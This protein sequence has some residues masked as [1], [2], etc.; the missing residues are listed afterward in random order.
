MAIKRLDH[1][2]FISHDMQ[3]TVDFY[4]DVIGLKLGNTLSIDTADS[5]YLYIEGHDFPAFHIGNAKSKKMQPKYERFSDLSPEQQGKFS[6]GSFDHFCLQLDGEDYDLMI[7][8]LNE[9]NLT[10]QT[11]SHDDIP[12]KQIWLLDPNGV[13]VELN[14]IQ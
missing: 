2:N 10:Y 5:I 4:C 1:V 9:L 12:L 7:E 3:A 11:H 13:R 14:F 6:T 8:K